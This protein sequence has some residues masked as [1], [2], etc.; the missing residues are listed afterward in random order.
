MPHDAWL[1]DRLTGRVLLSLETPPKQFVS[2][3]T[4]RLA[5]VQREG[6]EVVAQEATRAT[7]DPVIP[8]SGIKGA[9]RTVFELLSH[10]CDPF[11]TRCSR[12]SCCE[13]CSVFGI[14]GWSGRVDFSDARPASTDSVAVKVEQVPIPWLPHAE[15]TGGDFR[16]YDLREAVELDPERRIWQPRARNLTREVFTGRFETRLAFWNMSREEL[17]RLI[18]C[19]GF[20]GGAATRFSLRLG[21]VKYDGKGAVKVKPLELQLAAPR[22]KSWNGPQCEEEIATW[23]AAAQRSPWSRSFLP[24]LEKLARTLSVSNE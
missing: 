18:L 2:P 23:I 20:G 4:G 9:V 10:S 17:G 16:F 24:G 6:G 11:A 13:A 12:D 3:G 1:P 19:M 14:L 5:L 22:R 15:K 21:G 8:G 7:D